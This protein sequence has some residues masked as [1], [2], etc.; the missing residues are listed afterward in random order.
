VGGTV[1]G[2]KVF[3]GERSI[4]VVANVGVGGSSIV[5]VS[6]DGLSGANVGTGVGKGGCM[7]PY[8]T[9]AASKPPIPTIAVMIAAHP[10]RIPGNVVQKDGFLSMGKFLLFKCCESS[11]HSGCLCG[12]RNLLI[13][14]P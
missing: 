8:E 13:A 6:I 14:N 10:V 4:D 5:K 11:R 3:V 9:N 1:G 2:T 7:N 12:V